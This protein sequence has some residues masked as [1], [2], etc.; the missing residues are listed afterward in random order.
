MYKTGDLARWLPDGNIEFI[1]RNDNQVKIRGFRIELGEIESQLLD[2]EG[3]REAIVLAKEDGTGGKRLAAYYTTDREIGAE[4]LRN[5]LSVKLPEYMIPSAYVVLEA[6]PLTPNGKIDRKALPDPGGEAYA[7]GEYEAPQGE[8]EEEI[9]R[10][11]S[12]LLKVE[13]IGRHDNFFDLGG[14]SLLIIQVQSKLKGKIKKDIKVVDLFAYPTIKLL[15]NFINPKKNQEQNIDVTPT[16]IRPNAKGYEPIAIIGMNCRFPGIKGTNEFWMKL[17]EGKETTS[18]FTDEELLSS[19]VYP[20][21]LN[22]PNYVK[23]GALL[24]EVDMFDAQF[25]SYT[26]RQAEITDP[27]QRIFLECAHEILETSGYRSDSNS[28]RIGVFAGSGISQYFLQHLLSN[29]ILLETIDINQITNSNDKDFLSTQVSYKLNLKG[30]SINVQTAC[31]TSLVAVHSACQSLL[32]GECDIALAGGVSIG[33]LTPSGY[34]YTEGGIL[35]ADGHCRTFDKEANGMALGSGVAMVLLKRLGDALDDG[36][37]IEAVIKGSAINNDGSLK[38]GFTAPS[39]EGQTEVIRMAQQTAGISAETISY[40]EAHGT[41]TKLG[42]PIEIKA[43]TQAFREDTEDKGYCAIG[44]VK[45]NIGHTDTAAGVAGLIK[46]V[47]ALKHKQIPPS[48]HFK[49]P[50]PEIDFENSP[51]YVNTEL[52]E[53]K[54]NGNP[55]IAGVSSFG[56]GGTNAHVIVEEAPNL[57]EIERKARGFQILTLSAKTESALEKMT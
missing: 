24:D 53:W 27:Q 29:R 44:S 54:T 50:N 15:S 49:E 1:G 28:K 10:I 46:T 25:F 19:G 22:N 17:E 36:D 51:F 16:W 21:L 31:S 7:R 47:L 14:N 35:S 42:D 33:N 34:L 52:T 37:N 8:V 26:P 12:E 20:E 48:L 9:A 2:I 3:V 40:I 39:V 45:T 32:N 57:P 6:M 38:V 11:W 56:I 18:F 55:R 41:G 13:R 23:A 43:L 4:E 30:P 5:R